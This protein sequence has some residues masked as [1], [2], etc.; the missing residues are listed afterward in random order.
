[1]SAIT[2]EDSIRWLEQ[3][4]DYLYAFA[5]SRLHNEAVA[6]DF[7]QET[8]LSAF[9][10]REKFADNSSVKTWLTAILKHKI[11][12]HYRR[13]LRQVSF[14]SEAEETAFFDKTGHWRE[15]LSD[16]NITPEK[17]FERKEFQEILQNCLANMP[18]NLAAVFTLREFEGLETKEICEILNISPNNLWVLL[19]RSR[20][21][22][23]QAIE[24]RCFGIKTRTEILNHMSEI[25][26]SN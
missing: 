13:S 18:E 4:G 12:D 15:S 8:L 1:M 14:D 3:Y 16:W 6:E 19:H 2:K 22:L 10:S 25:V 24:S 17:L 20:L 5:L 23:R 7:V 11:F 26:F 9:E 21:R